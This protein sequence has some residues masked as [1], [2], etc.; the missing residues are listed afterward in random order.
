MLFPSLSWNEKPTR[1]CQECTLY[2]YLASFRIME[3]AV[4]QCNSQKTVLVT[5]SPTRC[6]SLYIM[7]MGI[8]PSF[9]PST[10]RPPSHHFP[11]FPLE[12]ACV[13]RRSLRPSIHS[14]M[15]AS[16]L[17]SPVAHRSLSPPSQIPQDII[18]FAA[19]QFNSREV[20]FDLMA[21]ERE[22]VLSDL[23]LVTHR[24]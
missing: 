5:Y 13:V 11:L 21:A 2:L 18:A 12:C 7:G 14:P 15:S 6:V 23:G 8:L 16:V 1:L 4:L 9:L 17:H 3:A 10:P 19:A 24:L 22:R 20:G